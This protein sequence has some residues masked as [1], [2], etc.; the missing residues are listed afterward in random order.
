[1]SRSYATTHIACVLVRT[2]VSMNVHSIKS[3]SMLSRGGRSKQCAHVGTTLI[4][5]DVTQTH[6]QTKTRGSYHALP[7]LW[8][9]NKSL[10][11]GA[12]GLFC[13]GKG[14]CSWLSTAAA[15]LR[16]VCLCQN[17]V[18]NGIKK[19]VNT[20]DCVRDTLNMPYLITWSEQFLACASLHLETWSKTV[21]PRFAER[22]SKMCWAELRATG[23]GKAKR[24]EAGAGRARRH[25]LWA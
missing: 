8:S 2:D 11:Q 7:T 14:V 18:A 4:S 10:F 24:A 25:I 12:C 1:M 15:S 23:E 5:H 9:P 16:N 19:T 22:S 21:R 20:C 13:P 17:S 6:K 3:G